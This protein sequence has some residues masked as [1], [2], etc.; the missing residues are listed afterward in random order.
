[1]KRLIGLLLATVMLVCSIN[2]AVLA[3]NTTLEVDIESGMIG[4]IFF[5]A[6]EALFEIT[7]NNFSETSQSINAE[8]N[9]V[10][11]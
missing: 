1:M 4:N 5:D 3:E 8:Y 11:K 7:F 10:N 2:V 9:F 6:S